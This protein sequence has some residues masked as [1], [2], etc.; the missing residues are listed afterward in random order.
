MLMR[1]P[2]CA[3]YFCLYS[4][5]ALAWLSSSVW[6]HLWQ[7]PSTCTRQ[8]LGVHPP[9]TPTAGPARQQT[10]PHV[11]APAAGA[12]PSPPPPPRAAPVLPR[13]A[14]LHAR[15]KHAHAVALLAHRHG[16]AERQ[17]VAHVRA[18]RGKHDVGIVQE[19]VRELRLQEPPVRVLRVR[20]R[21][22][23]RGWVRG[24]VGARAGGGRAGGGGGGGG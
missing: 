17:P 22:R 10:L 4:C 7:A 11:S 1:P 19:V 20:A 2:C 8:R 5:A 13:G 15:R 21:A 6:P 16:L 12:P 18:Q 9:P 3:W 23:V 24:W 14:L